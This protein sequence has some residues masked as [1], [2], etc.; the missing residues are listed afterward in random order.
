V[1]SARETFGMDEPNW[2]PRDAIEKLWP[3]SVA[4]EEL[5]DTEIEELRQS[6]DAIRMLS[7]CTLQADVEVNY[8]L[9]Q[10]IAI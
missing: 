4:I 9:S 3:T 2:L 7:R 5:T 10:S 8:L 6:I 1:I